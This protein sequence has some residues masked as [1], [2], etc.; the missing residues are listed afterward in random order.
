MPRFVQVLQIIIA[1][2]ILFFVG[3]DL[4]LHGVSIFNEK[5]VTITCALFVLLEI[6]LFVI[7]KLI[8]ED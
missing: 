2:V 8:E 5:Y 1:V 6:A 3:Y 7:Y 4:I